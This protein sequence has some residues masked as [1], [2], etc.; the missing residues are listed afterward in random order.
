MLP[1][2]EVFALRYATSA[3]TRRDNFIVADPHDGPMPM[4][5]FV[6]LIRGHGSTWLVDTG[7]GEAAATA[8]NRAR[9]RDPIDALGA[10]GVAVADLTGVILTHL[11]YDH[12]GN[13]G[14]LP[15]VRFHLQDRE[16]A[17]ATGRYMR[18]RL[19]RLVYDVDDVVDVV[20][21]AHTGRV[22]FHDG[23]RELAPGLHLIAA[24]GHTLGLQAVRV[25]TA[26]G[27]V[28]LASD[29][30]H[31]YENV[32]LESPFPLVLN[33]ADML[34]SQRRLL[35]LCESPDHFIPGHDPLV[36]ARFPRVG[37]P[38]HEVMA[39]HEDPRPR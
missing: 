17:Y 39:L 13:V 36:T 16:M 35:G 29:A 1:M 21:A 33:V 7:F 30:A 4:D 22:E 38:A 15:S 3:R 32:L 26:R 20:R 19:L 24:G 10:L 34:E 25:H 6:W 18:Y 14:R 2:Y 12:A 37:D 8:R 28:V 27:W 5:Y 9:L 23:D 31:Y 11:H